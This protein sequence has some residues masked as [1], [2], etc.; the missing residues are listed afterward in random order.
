MTQVDRWMSID[1]AME[2]LGK[3]ATSES[4]LLRPEKDAVALGI[5]SLQRS[6][7]MPVK[8]FWDATDP[9]AV[10]LCCPRCRKRIPVGYNI[11]QDTVSLPNFCGKCGQ[12]LQYSEEDYSLAKA[13]GR[14]EHVQQ[15]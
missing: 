12:R 6:Q 9:S 4:R 7:A 13:K 8:R 15:E 14:K 2:L 11:R 1:T 5:N 3:L 10:M